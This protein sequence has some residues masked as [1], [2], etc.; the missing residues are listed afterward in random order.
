VANFGGSTNDQESL[1]QVADQNL[2]QAKHG[3][4]NQVVAE[5]PND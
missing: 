4:R 5:A 2:Y 1:I 3:G